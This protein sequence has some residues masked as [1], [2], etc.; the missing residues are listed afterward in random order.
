MLE[1]IAWELFLWSFTTLL[2]RPVDSS[3]GKSNLVNLCRVDMFYTAV[4]ESCSAMS[5]KMNLPKENA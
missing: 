1:S 2:S 3:G 4:S 5:G